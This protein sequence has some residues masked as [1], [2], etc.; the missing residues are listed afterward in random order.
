MEKEP[1]YTF[2]RLAIDQKARA[3]F[4][5]LY[6][7]IISDLKREGRIKTAMAHIKMRREIADELA[8]FD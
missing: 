7:D 5:E 8:L 3:E 1:R 6:D 4:F 2:D